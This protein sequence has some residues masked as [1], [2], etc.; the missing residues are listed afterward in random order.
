MLR[1]FTSCRRT[2]LWVRSRYLNDFTVFSIHNLV[3]FDSY[4]LTMLGHNWSFMHISNSFSVNP[5]TL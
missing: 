5:G 2:G 4:L 1:S 3:I